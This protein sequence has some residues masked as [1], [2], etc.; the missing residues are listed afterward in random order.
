MKEYTSDVNDLKKDNEE[1]ELEL[2]LAHSRIQELQQN[3]KDEQSVRASL[4]R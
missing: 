2:R 1:K 4:G 3:S